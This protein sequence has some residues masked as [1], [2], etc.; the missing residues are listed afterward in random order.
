[1]LQKQFGDHIVT[2]GNTTQVTSF[3]ST[4]FVELNRLLDGGV[5]RGQLTQLMGIPTSGMSTLA[6]KIVASVQ[7]LG[8]VVVYLDLDKA[9]DPHYAVFCGVNTSQLLLIRPNYETALSML[10]DLVASGIPGGIVLNATSQLSHKQK[11][12]LA[13][14]LERMK[15]LLTRSNCVLLV[16]TR[17]L[18]DEILSQYAH[19]RLMIELVDWLYVDNEVQ[20]YQV[21]VTAVNHSGKYEGKTTQIAV[22]V[23]EQIA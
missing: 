8:E 5:R 3:I 19:L 20:G 22:A 11:Q 16:L 23:G 10:F 6:L 1:M 14:V 9:F 13:G 18:T 7:Q 2:K 17:P 12:A 15:P 21:R 4:G